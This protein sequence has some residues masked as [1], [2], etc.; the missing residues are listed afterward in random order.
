[1][2]KGGLFAPSARV[3]LAFFLTSSLL[4][5]APVNFVS[6]SASVQCVADTV[7][8]PCVWGRL[9]TAVDRQGL[10]QQF[11]FDSIDNT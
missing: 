2:I 3:C 11:V 4:Q 6:G 7:V 8:L 1:M 9:S 10:P 5:A